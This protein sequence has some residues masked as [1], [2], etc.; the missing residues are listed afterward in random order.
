MDISI[1]QVNP[2]RDVPGLVRLF[3][4]IA[5]MDPNGRM[6]TEEVIR[7][8]FEW[9][10][11]DPT[12]DEWVITP[13]EDR[14][15]I[16][17]HAGLW[18][19]PVSHSGDMLLAVHPG[20]RGRGGGRMLLDAVVARARVLGATGI[21]TYT[22]EQNLMSDRFLR[23]R[24][25]EPVAAFTELRVGPTVDLPRPEWPAGYHTRTHAELGDIA[26]V[27]DMTNRAYAEQWGHHEVTA[28]EMEPYLATLPADGIF[29]AF[30]GDGSPVGL[31]RVEVR[32]IIDP[33]E[34]S[35]YID[36]PG[37]LPEHRD[38]GLH[39]PLLLTAA[40]H[41]RGEGH[42][43]LALESWGDAEETLD[44]YRDLGF[45]NF[46]REVSYRLEL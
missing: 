21:G 26:L 6:R 23:E 22:D 41:L 37:V 27:V 25:F 15:T 9:F 1:R 34:P 43:P 5:S 8:Y 29:I 11:H 44:L 39:V 35:G 7:G 45:E 13:S 38:A 36:A 12:V 30:A 33:D 31:T 40:A 24:D 20:W 10:S 42:G 17:G 18:K 46:Q 19:L 3:A 14:D 2:E 16:I 32:E 4:A 28:E